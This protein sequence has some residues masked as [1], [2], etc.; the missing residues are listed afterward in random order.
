MD[1]YTS[2]AD[3]VK[4]KRDPAQAQFLSAGRQAGWGARR[5]R[6][7]ARR[8]RSPR[9]PSTPSLS[10]CVPALVA[11][12][13]ATA[14]IALRPRVFDLGVSPQ[15]NALLEAAMSAAYER[16]IISCGAVSNCMPVPWDRG[17]P[18]LGIARACEPLLRGICVLGFAPNTCPPE[19]FNP[20]TFSRDLATAPADLQPLLAMP[21][22]QVRGPVLG[23]LFFGL[24]LAVSSRLPF[25]ILDIPEESLSL[26]V[27]IRPRAC[28]IRAELYSRLPASEDP[29]SRGLRP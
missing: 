3:D 4:G 8:V 13:R 29:F 7:I 15:P 16:A 11:A 2:R 22:L 6:R 26:N 9:V 19:I 17:G 20:L 5:A 14:A 10:F 25:R 27:V 23:P 28:P 24:A 1:R 18:S 21:H 12:C